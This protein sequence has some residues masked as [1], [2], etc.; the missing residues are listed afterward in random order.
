M[1]VQRPARQQWH[2]RWTAAAAAVGTG[3]R[4]LEGRKR[5]EEGRPSL[6]LSLSLAR[7]E[8]DKLLRLRSFVGAEKHFVAL[9]VLLLFIFSISKPTVFP[10]SSSS[11]VHE[12]TAHECH[13]RLGFVFFTV[14]HCSL[15]SLR[16][17][18]NGTVGLDAAAANGSL[19]ASLLVSKVPFGV[20]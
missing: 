1:D 20:S 17:K 10:S 6:S 7:D 8:D 15:V 3:T 14:F 5:K 18:R 2:W 9:Q 12:R 16:D 19:L 4:A 11:T 13:V